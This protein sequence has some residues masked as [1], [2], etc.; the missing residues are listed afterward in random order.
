MKYELLTITQDQLKKKTYR[1]RVT[2]YCASEMIYTAIQVPSGL[3]ATFPPQQ[4]HIRGALVGNDYMV[5]NPNY[6]AV[7]FCALQLPGRGHRQ[8]RV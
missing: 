3:V 4:H 5:R 8:W 7:L 6:N 1:I 2:N